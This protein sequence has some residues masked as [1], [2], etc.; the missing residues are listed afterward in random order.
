MAHVAHWAQG[1]KELR[2]IMRYTSNFA[3]AAFV[4]FGLTEM[5]LAQVNVE[6]RLA[7]GQPPIVLAHRTAVFGDHPENT[8]AWLEA[9]IER[10]VDMLHINPQRT[11]DG[12][13]I[14]MHDQTLNRTTDVERVYPEGAPGGPTRQQRAGLDYVGDYTLE[15]IRRL[16]VTNASDGRT[17]PVPTLSEAIDLVD[18]RAL[19]LLGL[20][21]YEVE[22]LA[23]TLQQH[24]TENLQFFELYYSGTDQSKLRELAEATGVSVAVTLFRS[25]DYLADLEGIY[26]QLGPHLRTVSADIPRITP[27]FLTRTDE[28]GIHLIISGRQSG[29]DYALVE[30]ANPEPWQAL[31]DMG[32]SVFTGR[33]DEVLNLLGR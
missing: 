17:H 15:E 5:P 24:D 11:A 18:G 4:L 13:Y 22:S 9:G 20:K 6:A 28:L 2:G 3:I 8:L 1:E 31:L 26:D 25:T 21:A 33:P 10:G 23:A 27:E 30:D 12:Q 32:Y 14:L 7:E 29:E 16:Q 19:L